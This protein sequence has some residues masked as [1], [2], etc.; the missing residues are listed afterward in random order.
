MSK[1]GGESLKKEGEGTATGNASSPKPKA[2]QD[3][4]ERGS[5][6]G[7][8]FAKV[9]GALNLAKKKMKQQS[10]RKSIKQGG[11]LTLKVHA[12]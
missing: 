5:E 1:K 10:S 8:D 2:A 3:S 7:A 6:G 9:A 4:F 12:H 11:G